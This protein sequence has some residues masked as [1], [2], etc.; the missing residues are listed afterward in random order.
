MKDADCLKIQMNA[1]K[2]RNILR[3]YQMVYTVNTKQI[4]HRYAINFIN[5]KCE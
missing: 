4:F 5:F 3:L 2:R 1:V